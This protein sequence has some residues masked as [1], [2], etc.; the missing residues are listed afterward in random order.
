MIMETNK[1]LTRYRFIT[2]AAVFLL[3]VFACLLLYQ[4]DNK[5]TSPGPK[6]AN[7]ILVLSEQDME[8][9]P[10]LFLTEGWAYY[11]GRLLT[12]AD[13]VGAPTPDEYIFIGQY[14]GFDAGDLSAPPHGSATY[15]LTIT[16]PDELASYLLELPEIFSAYRAYGNGK[17]VQTM[18]DPDPASYRPKTGN[19]T[20]NIDAGGSTL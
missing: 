6:G 8:Q 16:V 15:R 12:P 2:L 4:Y 18:G 9:H 13:F 17:L 5:Y 1:W 14:G 7:G 19:R 11:G 20:V 10:V 3:A